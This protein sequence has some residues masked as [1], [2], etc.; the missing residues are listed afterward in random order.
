MHSLPVVHLPH[1]LQF[2]CSLRF[3]VVLRTIRHDG[4]VRVQHGG[5]HSQF[6]SQQFDQFGFEFFVLLENRLDYGADQGKTVRRVQVGCARLAQQVIVL[7]QLK[8]IVDIL[9][10]RVQVVLWLVELA[11]TAFIGLVMSNSGQMRNQLSAK[12]TFR[13][14]RATSHL[15]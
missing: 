14:E 5:I 10:V 11:S 8:R 6:G 2:V 4:L 3:G 13:L 12:S 1:I 9:K 15:D 7:E